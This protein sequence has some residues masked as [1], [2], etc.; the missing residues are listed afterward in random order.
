[1]WPS[2]LSIIFNSPHSVPQAINH[3]YAD[4]QRGP[5]TM[6]RTSLSQGLSAV[7]TPGD[8]DERELHPPTGPSQPGVL[9]LFPSQKILFRGCV[10][11]SPGSCCAQ[12]SVCL[13]CQPRL[14]YGSS[15]AGRTLR[16]CWPMLRQDRWPGK[17]LSTPPAPLSGHITS[18]VNWTRGHTVEQRGC[19]PSQDEFELS[20]T[21]VNSGTFATDTISQVAAS[22]EGCRGKGDLKSQIMGNTAVRW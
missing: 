17:C 3:Q 16:A 5:N 14:C 2:H 6:V 10:L 12:S 8:S 18:W 15:W 4:L 7:P 20:A 22:T 19:I 9:S 13:L 11:F 21:D 1:M